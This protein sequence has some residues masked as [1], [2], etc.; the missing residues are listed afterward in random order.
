MCVQG[1]EAFA[2]CVLCLINL[3]IIGCFNGV[4][5]SSQCAL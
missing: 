2:A 4:D 1:I 5:A 3:D